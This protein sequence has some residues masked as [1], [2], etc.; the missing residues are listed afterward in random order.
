MTDTGLYKYVY[1]GEIIYIGMSTSSISKRIKDHSKEEKFLPYIKESQIFY[2]PLDNHSEIRGVEKLLINKYKPL[3]NV[4]DTSNEGMIVDIEKCLPEWK[5]FLT[6]DAKQKIYKT[7]QK[8]ASVITNYSEVTLLEWKRDIERWFKE[9][10]KLHKWLIKKYEEAKTEERFVFDEFKTHKRCIPITKK[11]ATRYEQTIYEKVINLDWAKQHNISTRWRGA[12]MV[13]TLS[14][15]N[16]KPHLN[17]SPI[18]IEENINEY[19]DD[20]YFEHG[21]IIM[22]EQLDYTKKQ[23][24]KLSYIDDALLNVSQKFLIRG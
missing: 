14:E 8:V 18:S 19:F 1:N 20:E 2:I 4:I 13:V 23:L 7:K 21:T 9:Y 17:Y 3:L 11:E 24:E 5:L 22:K 15:I 16:G 12:V 10:K 6:K